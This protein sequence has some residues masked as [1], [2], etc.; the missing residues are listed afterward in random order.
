VEVSRAL[1][2][3]ELSR[4]LGPACV[5]SKQTFLHFFD[6]GQGFKEVPVID[7]G[8][9]GLDSLCLFGLPLLLALLLPLLHSVIGFRD[10]LVNHFQKVLEFPQLQLR[11]FCTFSCCLER[12]FLAL[13]SRIH[14]IRLKA[15]CSASTALRVRRCKSI[16]TFQPFFPRVRNPAMVRHAT[17]RFH[18]F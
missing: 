16:L 7:Q 1:R 10:F 9:L 14:K 3:C 2:I 6:L 8:I 18:F 12:I 13:E 17:V 15:L 5:S 4:A 11:C